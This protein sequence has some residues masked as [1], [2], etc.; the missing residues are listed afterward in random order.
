MSVLF[1]LGGLAYFAAAIWLSIFLSVK[2]IQGTLARVVI[3][4][5]YFLMLMAI[6]AGVFVA[7]CSIFLIQQKNGF[8]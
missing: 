3:A 6:T 5:V 8:H 4:A 1:A 2:T 7:G